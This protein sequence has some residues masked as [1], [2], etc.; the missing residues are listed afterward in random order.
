MYALFVLSFSRMIL[1][2]SPLNGTGNIPTPA[3]KS[4][5]ETQE[6]GTETRLHELEIQGILLTLRGKANR[7]FNEV[8]ENALHERNVW[9]TDEEH[10]DAFRRYIVEKAD[11]ELQQMV[12]HI[13]RQDLQLRAA[14]ITEEAVVSVLKQHIEDV[15]DLLFKHQSSIRNALKEI[16]AA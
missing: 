1:I 11:S 9:V 3:P 16:R 12:T 6:N 7:L 15:M 8:F 4:S 10:V 14:V 13:A 2:D 5:V